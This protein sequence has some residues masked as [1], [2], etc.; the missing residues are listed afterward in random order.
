M[1]TSVWLEKMEGGIEALRKVVVDDSLG[2]AAD[3]ERDMQG[4]VDGYAC[5]WMDAVSDP[6]KRSAFRHFAN[7]PRGDDTVRFVPERG[8]TTPDT[9]H[10]R[11]RT[12]SRASGACPSLKRQWVR[13]ASVARRARRGRH[14]GSLGHAAARGLP[15]DVARR[16][17]RDAEPVP[18]QARDGARARHRRRPGGRTQGRLPAAQEDVRPRDGGVPLR[19]PAR[20]R[21]VPRPRRRRPRPRRAAADGA[22]GARPRAC[23][24]QRLAP[25]TR[26]RAENAPCRR[27]ARTART[28]RSSAGCP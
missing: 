4:L 10:E 2:I 9:G 5:E 3:L 28:A 8:Q 22:A 1:R 20:D 17:V 6:D 13:V 23:A 21:D 24:T 18:A 16:V 14:R 7:D 27:R 25:R 15:A 11:R 19:G 26:W 12:R